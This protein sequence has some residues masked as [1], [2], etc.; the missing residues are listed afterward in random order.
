MASIAKRWKTVAKRRLNGGVRLDELLTA[1]AAG[2]G[3]LETLVNR[4]DGIATPASTI[5]AQAAST[6]KRP[7]TASKKAAGARL[8]QSHDFPIGETRLVGYARVSTDE[9]TT[10]LQL[11]ALRAAGCAVIHEALHRGRRDRD[12]A[13]SARSP[14]CA[15]AT[16]S[17]SGSSIG[18]DARCATC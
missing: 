12:R 13:L 8:A 11:D 9:Q 3:R 17:S 10:A 6:P 14:T 18:S 7:K 5:A 2:D 15:P 16:L 4:Y 1:H